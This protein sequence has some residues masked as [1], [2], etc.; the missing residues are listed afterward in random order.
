M[1]EVIEREYTPQEIVSRKTVI[2]AVAIGEAI[3]QELVGKEIS[4]IPAENRESLMST[5]INNA[6]MLSTPTV[7]K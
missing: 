3:V 1:S 5:I 2:C 6:L 4:N 7:V